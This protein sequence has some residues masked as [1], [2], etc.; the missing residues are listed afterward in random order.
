[1]GRFSAAHPDCVTQR[2]PG[3]KVDRIIIHA[4]DGT[5][6][7]SES[8]FKKGKDVRPVPTAA[9]YLVGRDGE[10]VQMVADEKK[11]YHCGDWN[12]RSIGV[13][14]E[15]RVN[16]W[17]PVKLKD[18]SIKPPP[19]PAGAGISWSCRTT[20]PGLFWM[21]PCLRTTRGAATGRFGARGRAPCFS[22]PGL[23]AAG[24]G[25]SA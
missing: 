9:H 14:L 18:G 21:G 13:E 5:L 15:V 3:V 16:P 4:M 22:R 24:R 1:M 25:R 17:A 12:S 19:F 20:A 7:G 6:K 23:G 10:I 11:C 8:W 2:K